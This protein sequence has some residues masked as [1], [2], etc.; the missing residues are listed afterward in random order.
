[1]PKV[2]WRRAHAGLRRIRPAG[3]ND[4]RHHIPRDRW[5]HRHKDDTNIT[6]SKSRLQR[7]L[8][9]DDRFTRHRQSPEQRVPA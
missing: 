8:D 1:M 7:P 3:T 2:I 9:S 5:R 6:A 4:R